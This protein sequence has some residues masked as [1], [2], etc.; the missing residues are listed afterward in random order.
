MTGYLPYSK[1]KSEKERLL[2][3]L[4]YM[5]D[6]HDRKTLTN[7][8]IEWLTDHIGTGIPNSN[9]TGVFNS[10]KGPG[11]VIRST[12]DHSI[13]VTDAGAEFLAKLAN[14]VNA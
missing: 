10:A 1:M 14:G 7:K 13:K 4:V 11:L 12:Q 6:V 8:E 3:V 5:R 9:I 2:W